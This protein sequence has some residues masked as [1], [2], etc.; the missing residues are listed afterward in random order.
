MFSLLFSNSSFFNRFVFEWDNPFRYG[1]CLILY[2]LKKAIVELIS[3]FLFK[4]YNFQNS[5]CFKVVVTGFEVCVYSQN[6]S[7]EICLVKDSTHAFIDTFWIC[8]SNNK[9][10]KAIVE[11]I[12]LFLLKL[13][14]FKMPNCFKT[15][16]IGFGTTKIDI[17][18]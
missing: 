15:V 1:T 4:I 3:L 10:E 17:F 12:C 14:N 8:F 11:L 5:N 13:Y 6:K 18:S 7:G 16:V 9:L 2:K